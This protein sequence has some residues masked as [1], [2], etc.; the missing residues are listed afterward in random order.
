MKLYRMKTEASQLET[1]DSKTPEPQFCSR[2]LKGRLAGVKEGF[3]PLCDLT[4][5]FDKPERVEVNQ[6]GNTCLSLCQK[7]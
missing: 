3:A 6:N 4:V 1:N 2:L 5:I 7:L